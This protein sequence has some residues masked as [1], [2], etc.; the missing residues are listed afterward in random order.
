MKRLLYIIP[1]FISLIVSGQDF[2]FSQ[3]YSSPIYISPSFAGMTEGIRATLNYR[4]QWYTAFDYGYNTTGIAVDHNLKIFNSGVGL[5]MVSD[6]AGEGLLHREKVGLNYNYNVP[7]T[8]G[9]FFKPGMEFSATYIGISDNFEFGSEMREDN[10]TNDQLVESSLVNGKMYLDAAISALFISQKYW[11]GA[12]L[13]HVMKPNESLTGITSE[14]PMK[15]IIFAGGKYDLNGRIGRAN[16][17]SLTFSAFYRG[18]AKYDQ[19]DLGISWLKSS[20]QVGLWYRGIPGFKKNEDN[21][22]NQDAIVLVAKYHTKKW[23]MS[24]SYDITI[25]RLFADSGGAHEIS[26]YY[27]FLEDKEIKRRQKKIKVPCPRF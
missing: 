26:L 12:T 10:P 20:I 2:Q 16:E 9:F 23:G 18:Q 7:L 17:E 11:T 22:I 8:R 3:I 13:Y 24:Y 5:V 4:T 6:F 14:V 21:S 15:Y 1:L 19:F 27:I 25:S